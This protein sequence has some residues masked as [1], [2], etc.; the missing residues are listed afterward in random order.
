MN[1]RSLFYY[2]GWFNA[3]IAGLS[4]LVLSYSYYADFYENILSYCIVFFLSA[5]FLFLSR[6]L[7]SKS[8]LKKNELLFLTVVGWL[9][10]PIILAI[11]YYTSGY[12]IDLFKAYFESMSGF[13]GYGF[14]IFNNPNG[15]D[16]SLLL[17]RSGT[18][19]VGGFYYLF[20]IISILSTSDINFVPSSYISRNKYS[21]NFEN[22]FVQNFFNI[23]YCYFLLSLFI[24]FILNFTSLYPFEKINLM[25]TAASSGGFFIKQELTLSNSLDKFIVS[26]SFL[27]SSLNIF[28]LYEL[29]KYSKNYSFTEDMGVVILALLSSFALLILFSFTDSFYDIFLLV[30]TS[31]STSG[32][33]L[34][35]NFNS[36]YLFFLLIL[37]FVGGSIFST[38][39]GFKF[40][41]ILFF[42]KKYLIEITK[43]LNPSIVLKKNIFDSKESIKNSDYY[44]GSL[45][46]ISYLLILSIGCLILS[47]NDLT[48]GDVF[49]IV[50]LTLNNTLPL[51][52]LNDYLTFSS[53]NYF[54]HSILLILM[55]FSK[56]Y[57]ISLLVIFKKLLWK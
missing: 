31:L 48:F 9:I 16:D 3:P 7:K 14:S 38:G 33:S 17:W 27:F 8:E 11:P 29:F 22:K 18:Q 23:F 41:R 53:L 35:L 15:I 57:L 51:N 45:I 52:Y 30:T 46:F 47:F 12:H 10:F 55:F 36:S 1:F 13:S 42:V 44:V 32:I 19:W 34:Q 24:L 39:S 40:M 43:L 37:T 25:M 4:A 56:V 50:F 21:T 54:S 5:F 26:I 6:A 2:L 20:T 49:K 28:I